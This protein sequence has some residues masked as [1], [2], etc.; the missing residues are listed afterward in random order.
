[1]YR[2]FPKYAPQG[3]DYVAEQKRPTPKSSESEA[4]EFSL[5][6]WR[7]A[8]AIAFAVSPGIAYLFVYA[9]HVVTQS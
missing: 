5:S 2:G 4:P 8:A 3:I 7:R 1:M 9:I 6:G